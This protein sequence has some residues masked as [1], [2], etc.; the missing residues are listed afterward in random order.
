MALLLGGC[1]I[2][3]LGDAPPGDGAGP[4]LDAPRL[5]APRYHL[6]AGECPPE[7]GYFGGT[8]CYRFVLASASWFEAEA[9]CEAN[10]EGAHLVI[11]DDAEEA[12]LVDGTVSPAIGN[13]WAGVTDLV[14]QGMYVGVTGNVVTFLPWAQGSPSGD[15]NCL[16]FSDSRELDDHAC[17]APNEYVCEY[18]GVPANPASYRP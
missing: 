14:N 9:A 18:D 4:G 11:V 16:Q 1:Q 6:D 17:T 7:Y 12:A 15:G 10:A 3:F 2:I 8:S 5:D 13:H